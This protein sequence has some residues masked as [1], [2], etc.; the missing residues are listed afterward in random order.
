MKKLLFIVIA[1]NI[2]TL[3]LVLTGV[4]ENVYVDIYKLI[5]VSI[6][7]YT[8]VLAIKEL[9]TKSSEVVIIPTHFNPDV[10]RKCGYKICICHLYPPPPDKPKV[11][12]SLTVS[13]LLEDL[14]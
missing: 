10:C 13:I 14:T 3:I 12:D 8:I 7:T 6:Y 4:K 5:A 11:S 1:L 2:I 9:Y